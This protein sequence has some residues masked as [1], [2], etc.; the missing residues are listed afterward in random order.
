MPSEPVPGLSEVFRCRLEQ[1]PIPL[2]KARIARVLGYRQAVPDYVSEAIDTVSADLCRLSAPKGGFRLLDVSCT[3]EGFSCG[4]RHFA[5]GEEIATPL[6]QAQRIALFTGTVGD[7]YTQLH[8]DYTEQD[9]PLLIYTL[10]AVGS[11]WAERIADRIEKTIGAVAEASGMSISNRYSPGYCGWK[12]AEQQHLF[13]LLPK[14]FCGITLSPSAMMHP[15]KSVSGVIGLGHGLKHN[16][17]P[18]DLCDMRDTC[19]GRS[20][21]RPASTRKP[22]RINPANQ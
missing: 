18:C 21:P 11:E 13:A 20:R 12:V 1:K 9:E 10:D 7:G 4:G 16:A 2:S 22:V 6:L 3:A 17:Y 5:T 14:D 8:R 19:R 15:I